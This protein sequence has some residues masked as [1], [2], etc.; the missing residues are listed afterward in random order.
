MAPLALLDQGDKKENL[1][2]LDLVVFRAVVFQDP[3]VLLGPQD[4]L[5]NLAV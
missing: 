1:E 2:C 3:L 4:F 5:E